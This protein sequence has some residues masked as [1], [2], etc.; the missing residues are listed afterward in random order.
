MPHRVLECRGV[1]LA[2]QTRGDTSVIDEALS[3]S[4]TILVDDGGVVTIAVAEAKG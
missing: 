3:T 4:L 1:G 2:R